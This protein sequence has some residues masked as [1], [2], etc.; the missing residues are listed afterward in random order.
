M[1]EYIIGSAIRYDDHV[2]VALKP[3]RHGDVIRSYWDETGLVTSGRYTQGFMTNEGRF[4]DRET[5]IC[6]A[7]AAG[8]I[9]PNREAYS[10]YLYSEDLW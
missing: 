5:G 9:G 2:R 8:Q 6:V 4:I 7:F 3:G 10:T 1:T